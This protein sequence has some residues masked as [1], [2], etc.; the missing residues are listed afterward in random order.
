MGGDIMGKIKGFLLNRKQYDRIRKMDHCQ[1]TLYV[2]SIYKSGYADGQKAAEGLTALEI[3]DVLLKV[4][5]LGEKRVDTIVSALEEAMNSKEDK[6]SDSKRE[7]QS[8][9]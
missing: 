1:M 9:S 6:K 5:G 2:E 8:N 3:R 7:N 4:K